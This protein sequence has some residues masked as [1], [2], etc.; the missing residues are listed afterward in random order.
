MT[1]L[2]IIIRCRYSKTKCCF[3]NSINIVYLDK[4]SLFD[5][6]MNNMW[7]GG[8]GWLLIVSSGGVMDGYL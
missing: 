5:I 1:K 8:H 4:H 3:V 7:E 6:A 2:L